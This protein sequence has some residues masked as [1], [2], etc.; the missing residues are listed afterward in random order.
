MGTLWA[1][2][3]SCNEQ[4]L[5]QHRATI[6]SL[7]LQIQQSA[8]GHEHFV[9]P[10][11]DSS[12]NPLDPS[13][14]PGFHYAHVVQIVWGETSLTVRIDGSWEKNTKT[15]GTTWVASTATPHTL[16]Q[17]GSFSYAPSRIF[18]E[19]TACHRVIIWERDKGHINLHILTDSHVL[20]QLLCSEK[21]KDITIKWTIDRIRNLAKEL[22]SCQVLKFSRNQVDTA[23]RLA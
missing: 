23:H 8:R 15:G 9:T 12:R 6:Q 14:P 5:R 16:L 21:A 1:I 22:T 17:E 20:M 7:Y 18:I 2:W 13:K 4:V 10:K 11:H 19:A 3:K